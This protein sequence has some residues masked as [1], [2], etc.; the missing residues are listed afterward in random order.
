MP[1][2]WFAQRT[3]AAVLRCSLVT[4]NQRLS[5]VIGEGRERIWISGT[6]F[7]TRAVSANPRLT[8]NLPQ[9]LHPL[10]LNQPD[11]D[12]E[13]KTCLVARKVP[14]IQ[15]MDIGAVVREQVVAAAGN[16]PGGVVGG[17]VVGD[18]AYVAAGGV[19][20]G[21]RPP[22]GRT[23]F[24]IASVSKVFTGT[25]LAN[26]VVAGE[27]RLDDVARDHLPA[28]FRLPTRDG[29]A[30]RLA[31][32]ATH[33][34]GLPRGADGVEPDTTPAEY[35]RA[36]SALSLQSVPGTTYA[37][38]NLGPQVIGVTLAGDRSFDRML[39]DSFI[40]TLGLSD[41]V[42]HPTAEQRARIAGGHDES[43]RPCETPTLP[44]GVASG[45][46]YGSVADLLAFLRAHW[47]P[48]T[49]SR[50]ADAMA[51]AIRPR[52]KAAEG[53]EVGLLWHIG[54][55]PDGDGVRAVWHNGA[56]PGYR[57]FVGFLPAERIGVAVL[58]STQRSVDAIGAALLRE[59]T[60]KT[61]A[62]PSG[63]T[64]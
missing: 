28:Y 5:P 35:A 2:H 12:L 31:D 41:I 56:L 19:A 48:A 25:A 40:A 54:A 7:V 52:A 32:L 30:I 22:D 27:R 38:S 39:Y 16:G 53:N 4:R 13:N 21:G 3:E 6:Y 11:R 34:S 55:V 10:L 20:A 18:R 57:S 61:S 51:L 17:V 63:P 26:S 62:T 47:D 1:A 29:V 60:Y 46:L 15:A 42:E 64:A 37:Y 8:L 49:P 9:K 43:G 33:T 24:R 58:T 50:T 23:L 59:V 14:K 45:G 36:V 44:R